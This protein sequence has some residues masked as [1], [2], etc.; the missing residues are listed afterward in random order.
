MASNSLSTGSLH[1]GRKSTRKNKPMTWGRVSYILLLRLRM[2][3]KVHCTT[4]YYLVTTWPQY[5][6]SAAEKAG[7][8]LYELCM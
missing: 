1:R 3:N 7:V 2:T 5:K 6:C 8:V 4:I